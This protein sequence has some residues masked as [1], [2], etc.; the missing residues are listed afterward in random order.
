MSH[1]QGVSSAATACLLQPY[2]AQHPS[3]CLV[4]TYRPQ[5]R[6]PF[7][8]GHATL[9]METAA[10]TRNLIFFINLLQFIHTQ[11]LKLPPMNPKK[12][13]EQEQLP[14][15]HT[16]KQEPNPVK[17]ST[18]IPT[19]ETLQTVPKS[20][21]NARQSASSTVGTD[22]SGMLSRSLPDTPFLCSHQ[23]CLLGR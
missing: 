16:E 19:L 6:N 5:D 3:P 21:S 17:L 8:S 22:H 23:S 4:S 15:S 11:S 9:S 20:H 14:E 18:Q 7:C 13:T 12:N 2:P 1:H 10:V